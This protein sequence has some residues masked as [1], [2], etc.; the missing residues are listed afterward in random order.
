MTLD[1]II[2]SYDALRVNFREFST[3][4]ED[5]KDSLL[6]YQRRFLEIKADLRPFHKEVASKYERRNDKSC[7]AVKYRIYCEIIKGNFKDS[8]GTIIEKLPHTQAEKVSAGT[9]TYK[10]FLN[11]RAFYKESYINISDIREEVTNYI[12]LI[13][14]RLNKNG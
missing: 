9:Q 1:E 8:D 14:D 5:T 2:E 11:Q 6:E 12:T 13:R 4:G 7:T 10:E 3:N